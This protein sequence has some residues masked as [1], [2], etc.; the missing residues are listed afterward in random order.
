MS[1]HHKSTDFVPL[2]FYVD[3]IS[4]RSLSIPEADAYVLEAPPVILGPKDL[5]MQL[6]VHTMRLQSTVEAL[7]SQRFAQGILL[8]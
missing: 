3:V 5:M 8:T 7:L 1:V 6:K 4:E 2:V